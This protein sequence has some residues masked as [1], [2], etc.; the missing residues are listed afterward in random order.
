[1]DKFTLNR[2]DELINRLLDRDLTNSEESAILEELSTFPEYKD[3]LADYLDV[4]KAIQSNKLV[5]PPDSEMDRAVFL[6]VDNISKTIFGKSFISKYKYSLLGLLLLMF[7][8]TTYF[9]YNSFQSNDNDEKIAN[10][11]HEQLNQI[12]KNKIAN[13]TVENTELVESSEIPVVSNSVST[14]SLRKTSQTD[15]FIQPVDDQL[16]VNNTST[17]FVKTLPEN[18]TTINSD[19]F[20]DNIVSEVENNK[21][22]SSVQ[23]S[24]SE[25][26]LDPRFNLK[27]NESNY[28]YIAP[29]S[30]IP[31]NSI[32]EKV[33]R[34]FW[35]SSGKSE[36]L[37]QY[38]G[39][40]AVSN[41]EK[42]LQG[43]NFYFN[44]Y[45][46]G[47]FIQAFDGIYL[48]GEFGAEPYSQI[49]LDPNTSVQYEQSP[50]IFYFGLAGKFEFKKFE[51]MNIHPA[52]QLF[53]GSS[54]LGPIVRSNLTLQYDLMNNF[55][56]FFGLEGG[57]VFYSNQGVWYNSSKLG[58]IGGLNIK[59]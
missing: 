53:A 33:S 34:A 50:N 55:G 13:E 51:I 24:M 31:R 26:I 14:S 12:E 30:V 8:A 3:N 7:T 45:C 11:K 42:S 6:E 9:T 47:G 5:I 25:N 15:S 49:Y 58:L 2:E 36:F 46:F 18:K 48:G 19:N 52:V 38:R 41:P 20:S 44:S 54:S 29:T 16:T 21:Y 32:F 10:N 1:M 28:E 27:I 59:F 35:Q 40:Y 43:R 37:L 57:S 56:F 17:N 4:Q 39:L 22:N 23:N